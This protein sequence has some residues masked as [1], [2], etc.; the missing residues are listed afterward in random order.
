MNSDSLLPFLIYIAAVLI[1]A[2]GM[3]TA[4]YFLGERHSAKA[5]EEIY[6]SGVKPTG[7]A[8]IHFPVHFY[9]IAMF[10]VIF[11]LE[12]V[13][14]FIWSAS[15]RGTGWT[16]YSFGLIFVAELAILLIYLWKTGALDFGP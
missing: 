14:L 16:G 8:R 3:L 4:S 10:F 6:E 12:A 1:L 2:V 11:D 5:K 13:F 15:L 9:L 7:S